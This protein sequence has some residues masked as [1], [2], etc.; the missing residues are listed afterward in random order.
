MLIGGLFVLTLALSIGIGV[1][2][3]QIDLTAV[4]QDINESN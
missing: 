3:R 2:S 1:M 4:Q